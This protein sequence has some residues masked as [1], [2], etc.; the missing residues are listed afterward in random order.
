MGAERFSEGELKRL[1]AEAERLRLN[2][3]KQSEAVQIELRRRYDE[4]VA[5]LRPM[6][7]IWVRLD[8]QVTEQKRASKSKVP[9]IT[10]AAFFVGCL[11]NWWLSPDG[12][13]SANFGTTIIIVAGGVAVSL[14]Y[15]SWALEKEI[16]FLR[17]KQD[18]YLYRW[19]VTGADS[20][21]F[22]NHRDRLR[23]ELKLEMLP[24]EERAKQGKELQTQWYVLRHELR[25]TLFYRASGTEQGFRLETGDFSLDKSP[26]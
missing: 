8:Q 2:F 11:L 26:W 3:E 17:E 19:Q 14:W 12:K 13:L 20:S 9:T 23:D 10:Y 25:Q 22:W 16:H 5:V 6:R 21:T 24:D 7:D 4:A 15:A 18:E 1:N